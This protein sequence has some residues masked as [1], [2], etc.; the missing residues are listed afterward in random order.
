MR[1]TGPVL[2]PETVTVPPAP[3]RR[4]GVAVPPP[5]ARYT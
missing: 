5:M 1:F 3:A 4:L 2:V